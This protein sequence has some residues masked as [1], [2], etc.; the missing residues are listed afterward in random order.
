[1]EFQ[2]YD[3]VRLV[4]NGNEYG[5]EIG[6]EG[7]IVEVLAPDVYMVEF[8]GDLDLILPAVK[9]EDLALVSR[10]ESQ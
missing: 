9:K 3:V 7:A 2:Q 10:N 4:S 6:T 1:M 5:F 8:E